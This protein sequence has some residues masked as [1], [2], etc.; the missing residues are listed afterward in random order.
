MSSFRRALKFEELRSEA[1]R[2]S[3]SRQSGVSH[4]RAMARWLAGVTAALAILVASAAQA[5]EEYTLGP[6]DVI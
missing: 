4:V 1:D 5:Q 2:E 3:G 6:E